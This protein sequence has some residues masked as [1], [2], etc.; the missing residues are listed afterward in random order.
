MVLADV[1]DRNAL[2]YPHQTAFVCGETRLTFAEVARRVG[3]L[4]ASLLALGLSKGERL[5]VIANNC[6][7]FLE[8][9]LAAGQAGLVAVPIN[10]RLTRREMAHILAETQPRALAAE[11][12]F[13]ELV[14]G[15]R[16]QTPSLRHLI[17]LDS[18]A[19]GY[20]DYE[21]LVRA[22]S[23]G[24]LEPVAE[25]DLLCI[26]YTGGTSGQ[27]KGVMHT[28]RSLLANSTNVVLALGLGPS[29]I[30]LVLTPLFHLA[31]LW[32]ALAHLYVGA[33][34]VV[35]PRFEAGAA[36]ELIEREK[37]TFCHP[38]T[39]MVVA[40]LDHPEVGRYDL[41]SLHT[42]QC[43]MR[44]PVPL[45]RRALRVFGN[46]FITAYGLT[47]AG[48]VVSLMPREDIAAW[49]AIAE[50][51]PETVP[52]YGWAGREVVNVQVRVVDEGDRDVPPGEV[53][54]IIVKGEAVM[55]G[56]WNNPQLTAQVLRGGWLH[57]GDLVVMDQERY[58]RFVDRQSG[59]I[60]SGGERV[61]PQEVEEVIAEHPAVLEVA[62]FGVPH[63]RWGETVRAAVVLRPGMEATE[64]EI[65]QHCRQHL[66]GYKKP[67]AVDFLEA[68]P[69]NPSG[70]VLKG[71]LRSRYSR[72]EEG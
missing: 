37:V 68:L 34:S 11:E 7:R 27:P 38:V 69:R 36:L 23:S 4:T 39:T 3:G 45:F 70:K 43:S 24:P 40:M 59:M 17:S 47:E 14:D 18:P 9:Y 26:I 33:T 5:A 66:A 65:I 20:L 12:E 28:H 64:E 6:H 10:W 57:T 41:S 63:Y 29:D 2:R 54:E 49:A 32:P 55:K 50:A 42:I 44:L 52:R 30:N 19:P 1:T 67:T 60:K 58:I 15:L 72:E 25:D 8:L 13:F 71:E 48:P 53:G 51:S 62:V 56:Y 35:L 16:P 31:A 46:K 21:E 61:F 22:P